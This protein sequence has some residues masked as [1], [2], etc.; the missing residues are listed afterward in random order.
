MTANNRGAGNV[1]WKG[2]ISKERDKLKATLEYKA[3]AFSVYSRDRFLCQLC[4][5]KCKRPEAHH[6]KPLRDV[7]DLALEISNGITL[8]GPCH[9]LTYGKESEF[10]AIFAAYVANGVNSG[11]LPPG[12][13]EDN[14]EPSREGN[15][16][17]GA[18]I[19]GRAYPIDL[20]SFRKQEVPCSHCGVMLIRHPYRVKVQ[21]RFF[22][23][24][25]CKGEWQRTGYKG[26]GSTS[27][28]VQCAHCGVEIVRPPNRVNGYKAQY[29]GM[30]C[31]GKAWAQRRWHGSNTPTSAL[32]E[33][34]D[35][36]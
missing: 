32:R 33:S 19:R 20:S 18:T 1:N 5:T 28:A 11:N 34:D 26:R 13:A 17:E 15:L 3:W 27:I 8:C 29:C 24:H 25:A 7:P 4:G 22:C 10:E 14:P 16:S 30:S 23:D 31:M 36:I 9:E 12:N 21:K 2:G 35:M 6:I